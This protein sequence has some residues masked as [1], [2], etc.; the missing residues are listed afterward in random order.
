M[1]AKIVKIDD[2]V[3]ALKTE[4]DKL[5]RVPS[6]RIEFECGIGDYVTIEKDGDK[7]SIHSETSSRKVAQ[8]SDTPV[9]RKNGGLNKQCPNCGSHK[10][11]LS[12]EKSKH[13]FL[14]FILF[15]LWYGMWWLFKAM[16]ALM[17]L[18]CWDWWFAIIKK[19]QNKGYVWL[20]KRMVENHTKVY[21]CHDCGN[22]FRA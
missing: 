21:Y 2:K 18:T 19:S 11:Q 13:G 12:S 8:K 16:L 22:N 9:V 7:I 5:V 6:S 1:R 15:G 20:S 3:I 4:K 10:V 14:W 17:V